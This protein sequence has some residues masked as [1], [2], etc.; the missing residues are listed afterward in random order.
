MKE[1]LYVKKGKLVDKLWLYFKRNLKDVRIEDIE[2]QELPASTRIIIHTPTPGLIIGPK[3]EKVN[4]LTEEIKNIFGLENPQIDVKKLDRDIVAPQVIAESIAKGI[5]N[6]KNLRALC[7]MYLRRILSHPEV[8]G[9]EIIVKGKVRG[10]RSQRFRFYQGYMKK[11]GELAE[12]YVKKGFATACPPAGKIGIKVSVF[13]R[14]KE[15]E[16]I[17]K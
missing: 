13:F 10:S 14:P 9:A 11:S 16:L 1:L 7:E 15:E 8:L 3:G 5:E 4:E 6:R 17:A 12:R 2:V